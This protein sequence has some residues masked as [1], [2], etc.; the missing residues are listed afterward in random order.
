MGLQ[1]V[2]RSCRLTFLMEVVG[3]A[4]QLAYRPETSLDALDNKRLVRCQPIYKQNIKSSR[5]LQRSEKLIHVQQLVERDNWVNCTTFRQQIA[6]KKKKKLSLNAVDT[7]VMLFF[8]WMV[9]LAM[10]KHL[11]NTI[12]KGNR[13]LWQKSNVQNVAK[14]LN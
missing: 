13:I 3:N 1:I 9:L 5:K 14:L 10:P 4:Y 12:K 11:K 8:C 2:G 6:M 7:K